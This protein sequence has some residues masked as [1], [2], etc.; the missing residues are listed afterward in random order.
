VKAA[1]DYKKYRAMGCENIYVAHITTKHFIRGVIT[2]NMRPHGST[3][4]IPVRLPV[5]GTI[6]PRLVIF[7]AVAV[8]D[9]FQIQTKTCVKDLWFACDAIQPKHIVRR[10]AFKLPADWRGYGGLTRLAMNLECLKMQN[11][12][13]VDDRGGLDKPQLLG[14]SFLCSSRD[15]PQIVRSADDGEGREKKISEQKGDE[16]EIEGE[17]DPAGRT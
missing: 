10:A 17:E 14:S 9:I 11:R 2:I 15:G 6:S 13:S 4:D 1:N 3:R 16:M 7:P 12:R 8:M 5:I